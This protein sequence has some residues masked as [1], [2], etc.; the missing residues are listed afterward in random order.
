MIAS[1]AN[2]VPA[3]TLMRNSSARGKV[4]AIAF[5]A[6]AA[7]GLGDHLGFCAGVEP[8]LITAMVVAKIAGG[9]MSVLCAMALL[10]MSAFE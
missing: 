1:C 6:C 10:K 4:L 9:I 5:N 2:A 8:S 7:F 3:F